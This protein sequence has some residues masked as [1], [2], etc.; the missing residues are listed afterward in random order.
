MC[1]ESETLKQ[2]K[3]M[4]LKGRRCP[5]VLD[6]ATEAFPKVPVAWSVRARQEVLMGSQPVQTNLDLEEW[7]GSNGVI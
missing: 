3:R 4:G 6:I 2:S 7:L 5:E 1:R